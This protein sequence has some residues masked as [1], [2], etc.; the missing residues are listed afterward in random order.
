VAKVHKDCRAI[1]RQINICYIFFFV[2]GWYISPP[3][4]KIEGN[5]RHLVLPVSPPAS[6]VQVPV[7]WVTLF[8]EAQRNVALS[9][10]LV[11]LKG[12]AFDW[13]K[14][15]AFEVTKTPVIPSAPT[16]LDCWWRAVTL[17]ILSQS[18]SYDSWKTQSL[19]FLFSYSGH[20]SCKTTIFLSTLSPL[21]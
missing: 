3:Q 21:R 1:D 14:N 10:I 16:Y 12:K 17:I 20:V 5:L 19:C 2:K 11:A 9:I 15:R 6:M 18:V 7:E 4:K 13:E 8:R